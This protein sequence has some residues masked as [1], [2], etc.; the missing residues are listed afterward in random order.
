MIFNIHFTILRTVQ[1][2]RLEEMQS[3]VAEIFHN[4]L[5]LLLPD[6]VLKFRHGNQGIQ[7]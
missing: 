7:N 5:V 6:F 2:Q 4:L 3:S 1:N